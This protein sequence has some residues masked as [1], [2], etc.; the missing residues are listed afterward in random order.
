MAAFSS[1]TAYAGESVQVP[2]VPAGGV[3][4]GLAGLDDGELLGILR[5]LP[6][7]SERRA[8]ACEL[9]VGRYRNL[10]RSCV[11]RYRR[12]PEPTQDLMQV[13]YVGL[14]KAISNF[15][16]ALGRSLVA[17]AQPYITGELKRHFRDKSW[18]VH[19]ERSV[20]ELVLAVRAAARQLTQQLGHLPADAELASYLG[21]SDADIRD[22]RQAELV[23]RPW[24]LDEPL[25][26]QDGATSLGDL[27]GQ[28]DPQVEHMLSMRAVATHW[29]ELP[30]RE[31][32]ILR[33]RFHGDMTQAEIGQQLGISQMH[34]SRLLA[35]ALGYLR[36]RLLGLPERASGTG[37][38]AAPGLD[39]PGAAA[40]RRRAQGA[41]RFAGEVGRGGQAWRPSGRSYP[42]TIK[43]GEEPGRRR[44][45]AVPPALDAGTTASI[46]V[47]L[48][49]STDP[50]MRS[51]ASVALGGRLQ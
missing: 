50:R 34:V 14:L 51:P 43:P 45:R 27:L 4:Q 30:L 12:S 33:M 47:I 48:P 2:P 8:A 25:A 16:P 22:A 19:V 1:T 38:A 6:H 13:G 46:S 31:Q 36:P 44:R 32:Q 42:M 17:Y 18:Q 9:L 39:L 3:L 40:L 37:L 28:D 20:Q 35:H 15:D 24:S 21:V 10:V 29:G 41:G 5:S 26:G 11:H 23:L 49:C 7:S